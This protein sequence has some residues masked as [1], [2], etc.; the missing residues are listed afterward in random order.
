[1]Q[2]K[3]PA[4]KHCSENPLNQLYIVIRLLGKVCG[5]EISVKIY[6]Q[7]KQKICYIG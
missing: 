5:Y 3:P 4:K 1:M 2:M 6:Q 7:A